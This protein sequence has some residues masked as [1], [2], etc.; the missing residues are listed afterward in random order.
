MAGSEL[1]QA[2]PRINEF[3]CEGVFDEE[4]QFRKFL[5]YLVDHLNL[6]A[7][8][9]LIADRVNRL[10]SPIFV[11]PRKRQISGFIKLS[12]GIDEWQKFLHRR[13]IF[14]VDDITSK[15]KYYRNPEIKWSKKEKI[16]LYSI[17]IWYF[18][19]VLGV[20]N[21][22]VDVTVAP[23]ALSD[24]ERSFIR[25]IAEKISVVQKFCFEKRRQQFLDKG[26][27]LAS[28]ESLDQLLTQILKLCI[29]LKPSHLY[30]FIGVVDKKQRQ[31][32]VLSKNHVM[33]WDEAL[34]DS[35]L[36]KE[37][38]FDLNT[39][40]TGQVVKEQRPLLLHD[41]DDPDYQYLNY[42]ETWRGV[43][44]NLCFPIYLRD[45]GGSR[46]L[47]VVSLESKSHYVFSQSDI[48]LL[49][50][51]AGYAA[52]AIEKALEFRKL[53]GIQEDAVELSKLLGDSNFY[54]ATDKTEKLI[55][56]ISNRTIDICKRIADANHTFVALKSTQEE[57]LE[58][59]A[60]TTDD[61]LIDPQ[62]AIPT[63]RGIVGKVVTEGKTLAFHTKE[64]KKK[65]PFEPIWKDTHGSEIESELAI[66]IVHNNEA[67][68]VINIESH[69]PNKFKNQEIISKLEN[70]A[71]SIASV[72]QEAHYD[73]YS[74]KIYSKEYSIL[75]GNST[76]MERIREEIARFSRFE[77]PV[78]IIGES[79]TG[80]E[81]AARLIHYHS[82]RRDKVFSTISC[83]EIKEDLIESELFGH[84]KGAFTG[85]D[86]NRIGKLKYSDGGTV[87][88]DELGDLPSRAQGK[89][90]RVLQEKEI[91]PLGANES[92]IVNVRII[93]A[94]NRNLQQMVEEGTFREDLYYRFTVLIIQVPPLRDRRDDI[95]ELAEYFVKK[96]ST[97]KG[98]DSTYGISKLAMRNLRNYGWPGN[99]RQLENVI[100]RAMVE[101]SKEGGRNILPRHIKFSEQF[102]KQQIAG[103]K[104][105][106]EIT[107]ED[108]I[109]ELYACQGIKEK[110]YMALGISRTKC[111]RIVP[112]EILKKH[113]QMARRRDTWDGK[114]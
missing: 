50:S 2:L 56:E 22:Y 57:K 110:M 111:E 11:H 75:V 32:E 41:V 30:G 18:N 21:C 40:I 3:I 93:A 39:G 55:Q 103:S 25:E 91:T 49:R 68:G 86:T 13:N 38:V 101:L 42:K 35:V 90:L 6:C 67:I 37:R 27:E 31:V 97:R 36:K 107:P 59:K 7:A 16:S 5:A 74:K 81:L 65:Y 89:I 47:A 85:A 76:E 23:K 94:T 8:S 44:S 53:E 19:D 70:I 69:T 52:I 105:M 4:S 82:K 80:K 29:S 1:F 98:F 73:I 58:I 33:G 54:I 61:L 46:S 15:P 92:S 66:P 99:V 79:G 108:V 77:L 104:K 10:Y 20:L 60:I 106:G 62:N 87:F 63:N 78:L 83:T 51:F 72:L 100:V 48:D 96:Y 114:V 12:Y 64:E 102:F 26:R 28:Y 95:D 84:V 43:K 34:D 9:I 17:P 71:K 45:N 24:S 113:A 112:K 88:F 109:K 14:Y